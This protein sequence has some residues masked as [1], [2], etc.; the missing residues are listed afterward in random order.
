MKHGDLY[1]HHKNKEYWYDGIALPISQLDKRHVAVSENGVAYDAA[2]PE[3]EEPRQ[4][5]LYC[6]NGITFVDKETPHVVYQSEDDYDTDKVWVR[7][8]DEFFGMVKDK[9]GK[10]VRRFLKKG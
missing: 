10:L 8:V 6:S 1:N 4:V 5:Q 2:T 7:E 3:G 9:Q